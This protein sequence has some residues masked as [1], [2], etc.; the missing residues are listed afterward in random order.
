[1]LM[2]IMTIIVT[3]AIP[4]FHYRHVNFIAVPELMSAKPL[5]V[6]VNGSRGLMLTF[7]SNND[8]ISVQLSA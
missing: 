3:M 4:S 6:L 7:S 2:D 8:L 5:I 1:M